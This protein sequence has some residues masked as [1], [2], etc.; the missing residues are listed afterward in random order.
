MRRALLDFPNFFVDTLQSTDAQGSHLP[1]RQFAYDERGVEGPVQEQAA[2]ARRVVG[3][4]LVWRQCGAHHALE[5]RRPRL[6]R[7]AAPQ[8][9]L[10]QPHISDRAVNSE[11]V[12]EDEGAS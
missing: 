9:R 1:E 7:R 2:R 4:A 6:Q 3:A 8:P 10:R 5:P 11:N 12:S